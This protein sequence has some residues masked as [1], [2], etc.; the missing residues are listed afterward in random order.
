M[1]S[2]TKK[3]SLNSTRLA[4]AQAY[5]F[6]WNRYSPEQYY[7]RATLDKQSCVITSMLFEMNY[8]CMRLCDLNFSCL[9]TS[10]TS[11]EVSSCQNNKRIQIQ[12]GWPCCR[13]PAFCWKWTQRSVLLLLLFLSSLSATIIPTYAPT[14]SITI[15][16]TCASSSPVE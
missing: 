11:A 4:I 16:P 3:R 10:I 6:P 5:T 12:Y 13:R 9:S 8:T 7:A 2:G 1:Y 15:I 14:L